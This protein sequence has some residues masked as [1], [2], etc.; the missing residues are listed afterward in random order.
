MF[1]TVFMLMKEHVVQCNFLSL[2]LQQTE[3]WCFTAQ[4]YEICQTLDT[5]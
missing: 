1:E 2:S 4:K 3:Q 5:H